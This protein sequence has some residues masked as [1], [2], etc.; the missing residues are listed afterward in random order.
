MAQFTRTHGDFQPVLWL[1]QPAY[2]TGAVNAVSSGLTVQPQGPKLDFFTIELASLAETNKTLKTEYQPIISFLIEQKLGHFGAKKLLE[3]VDKVLIC[4]TDFVASI[5]RRK[6]KTVFQ[7]FH[8]FDCE[9]LVEQ[10]F[11]C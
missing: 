6:L 9:A 2:T 10:T 3:E 1:D 11:G 5:G 7:P 4:K 8:R